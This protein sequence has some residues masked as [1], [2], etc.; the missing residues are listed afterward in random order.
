MMVASALLSQSAPALPSFPNPAGWPA[1]VAVARSSEIVGPGVQHDRFTL[2]TADGPLVV[3][4]TTVDVSDPAVRLAVATHGGVISGTGEPLTALAARA[5]AEAALNGDYFDI[6]ETGVPLGIVESG[7]RVLH[8]PDAAAA[9]IIAPGGGLSI[10]PVA[11]NVTI[12]STS[13]ARISAS[14]VNEWTDAT[15]LSIL[16]PESGVVSA[17]AGAEIVLAPSAS[18][19]LYTVSTRGDALTSLFPLSA[20]EIGVAA[21]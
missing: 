16:T 1:I 4:I 20:G 6:G 13:G 19:G 3:H 21:H 15:A 18:A 5:G 14:S 17:G 2:T 8:Q 11:L 12:A 10:G 7:G 9:L